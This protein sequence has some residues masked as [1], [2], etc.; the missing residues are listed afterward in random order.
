MASEVSSTVVESSYNTDWKQPTSSFLIW[1]VLFYPCW[2][3]RGWNWRKTCPIHTFTGSLVSR[4]RNSSVARGNMTVPSI[5]L[6]RQYFNYLP[7]K[8]FSINRIGSTGGRG[9]FLYRGASVS[10][11]EETAF[12]YQWPEESNIKN[13][14]PLLGSLTTTSPFL[15]S[16][17]HKT[18]KPG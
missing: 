4:E 12:L 3:P 6:Q 14:L 7:L 1:G 16:P 17:F 11:L 10:F 13:M 5:S 9:T 18:P 2:P 15:F 8:L